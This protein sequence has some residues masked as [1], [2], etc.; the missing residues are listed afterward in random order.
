MAQAVTHIRGRLYDERAALIAERDAALSDRD[1][2]AV[3]RAGQAERRA[4]STLEEQLEA[5]ADDAECDYRDP[6]R[7]A[8]RWDLSLSGLCNSSVG[9]VS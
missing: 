3:A 2:D 6:G 5:A 1:D 4:E 9:G 7:S 8:P